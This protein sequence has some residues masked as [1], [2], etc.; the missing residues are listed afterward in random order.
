[1]RLF[2]DSYGLSGADRALLVDA[3]LANHDW[4]Y[5]VVGTA[6]ANGHAAFSDYWSSGAMDRAHATRQWYVEDADV[7]QEAVRPDPART[8]RWSR[9]AS[10][11][12]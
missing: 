5:D 11:G 1:L 8:R 3:V 4:C 6:A 7:L 10:G 2:V 9:R 12:R